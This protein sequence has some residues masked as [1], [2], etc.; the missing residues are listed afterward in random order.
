MFHTSVIAIQL[1]SHN[2]HTNLTTFIQISMIELTCVVVNP[3]MYIMIQRYADSTQ[4]S[5]IFK[6]CY[7]ETLKGNRENNKNSLDLED[8]KNLSLKIL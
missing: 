7:R 1:S 4:N 2:A 8:G 6:E 5:L 3:S